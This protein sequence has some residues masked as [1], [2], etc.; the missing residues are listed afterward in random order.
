MSDILIIKVQSNGSI[1][2]WADSNHVDKLP[3]EQFNIGEY[4]TV[5]GNYGQLAELRITGITVS[6]DIEMLMKEDIGRYT[7]TYELNGFKN[8]P[9]VS[10]E[11]EL[12]E[13]N[14][15]VFSGNIADVIASV[16]PEPP[17]QEVDDSYETI[18]PD[19][20]GDGFTEEYENAD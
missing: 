10:T 4:V 6:Q 11:W 15:R 1:G 3:K 18:E 13:R 17:E 14:P 16:T 7:V 9:F 20:I 5:V 12:L 19:Y 8:Y 2:F